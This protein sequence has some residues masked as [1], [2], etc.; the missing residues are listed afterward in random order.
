VAAH[1]AAQLALIAFAVMQVQG[2]VLRGDFSTVIKTGL[3]AAGA[4]F[5]LGLIT[6]EVARRIVE[7]TA[8]REFQ[9]MINAQS[10]DEPPEAAPKDSN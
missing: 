10:T 6:G 8:E 3:I 9:Q 1:F 4:F 5:L 7:E 2:M